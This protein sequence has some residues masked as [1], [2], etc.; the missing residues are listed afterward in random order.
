MNSKNKFLGCR[1]SGLLGA[2]LVFV[3]GFALLAFDSRLSR[4]LTRSSYDWSFDLCRFARPDL[5]GSDV[6]IVYIDEDSLKA[7]NQPLN[8]P[9]DRSLHANLLERLKT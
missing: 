1:A 7:L 6:V 4:M 2:V 8:A 3:L 9:M 5:N